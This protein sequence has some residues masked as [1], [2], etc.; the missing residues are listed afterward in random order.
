MTNQMEAILILA[1][2]S[3]LKAILVP[4][5]DQK[6]EQIHWDRLGGGHSGGIKAA[7]SW[8][9]CIWTDMQISD[10][11]HGD[12]VVNIMDAYWRDPFEGFGMMDRTLQ[13]LVLK[14]LAHRHGVFEEPS[15][16]ELY[17]RNY[18]K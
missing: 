15:Q 17:F 9:Y 2:D 16:I 13:V 8:A 1:S 6:N 4:I 7:L 3:R 11:K 14:A 10:D 12:E 18:P 5:I